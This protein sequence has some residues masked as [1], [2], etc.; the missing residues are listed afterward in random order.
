MPYD[1]FRYAQ[2]QIIPKIL[3]RSKQVGLPSGAVRGGR[4]QQ[5]SLGYLNQIA[6]H[7]SKNVIQKVVEIGNME[8]VVATI[9]SLDISTCS[10][11]QYQSTASQL[12]RAKVQG[13]LKYSRL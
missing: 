6:I 1:I 10:T 9:E 4:S 11:N 7:Q 2:S 8:V 5:I 12:K 13:E 3:R